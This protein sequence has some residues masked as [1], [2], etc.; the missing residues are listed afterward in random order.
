M[1][2][3]ELAAA[4]LSRTAVLVREACRFNPVYLCSTTML[5]WAG[6]LGQAL[7]VKSN[8]DYAVGA[9]QLTGCF[10]I[11]EAAPPGTNK[12]GTAISSV[13]STGKS[14]IGFQNHRVVLCQGASWDTGTEARLEEC[15]DFHFSESLYICIDMEIN[16]V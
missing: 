9:I 14:G 12:G 4:G 16:N 10:A 11:A 6:K 3:P 15:N 1:R 13:G 5:T 7:K 2:V 8:S